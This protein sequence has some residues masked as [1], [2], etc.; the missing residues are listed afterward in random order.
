M[1]AIPPDIGLVH[2]LLTAACLI[3]TGVL[4]I[5]V[6]LPAGQLTVEAHAQTT[7]NPRESGAETI[8]RRQA[9]QEAKEGESVATGRYWTPFEQARDGRCHDAMTDLKRL[10]EL[11]RGYENAQHIYGLCLIE[12]GNDAQGNEWVHRAAQAG[13]A[14]A[15][16]SYLRSYLKDG[17]DHISHDTAAKWLYLYE[18]NP[19]RL[20]IG[21]ED[22]LEQDEI[23]KI[24]RSIPRAEYLKGLQAARTWTPTFWAAAE[25]ADTQ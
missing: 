5:S 12:T 19:L 7:P 1:A 18:T 4:A 24:R 11:G 8:R 21:A 14:D 16:A 15:Q 3:A 2:R 10:A 17:T 23:E 13:L 20:A 25:T 6:T 9:E 22:I